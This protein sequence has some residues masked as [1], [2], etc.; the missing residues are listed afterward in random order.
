V[1]FE[2][3]LSDEIQHRVIWAYV[4]KLDLVHWKRPSAPAPMPGKR[5]QPRLHG[6][7]LFA[8]SQGVGS[9]GAWNALREP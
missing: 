7:V 1:T 6:V 2:A 8:T 9:A 4:Q 3:L 5:R